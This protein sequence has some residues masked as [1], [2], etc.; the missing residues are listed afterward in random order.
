MKRLTALVPM[1]LTA[2]FSLPA[3]AS[4]EAPTAQLWQPVKEV[5]IQAD[6]P[7]LLGMPT[8]AELPVIDTLFNQGR[9]ETL[10][11]ASYWADLL[12][13]SFFG[14]IL[15]LG[16]FVVFNGKS[17]LANGFSGRKVARWSGMDVFIHWLGAISCL[18]LIIT[19]IVMAAGRFLLEP[20]M[21]TNSWMGV[22]NTSVGLH[23]MMA[24]PFLLGWAIMVVKWAAKQMPESCDIGW[25][26]VM[27]GYLNFGSFKNQH[28]D[29]GFANA[30]E[31]LW[32]WTF[33]LFGGVLVVSGLILMFPSLVATKDAAN[34]SLIL[35]LLSAAILGM[36][37]VVHIFMATVMSEGGMECMVSGYC[38]ENWAKQHHNLWFKELK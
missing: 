18:F 37:T 19:G 36:F 32:F 31:K 15:L 1:M 6:I 7:E 17:K 27:G 34:L 14:M 22:I 26:K 20:N 11:P 30:G 8:Q 16:I 29:A 9:I 10:A 3:I 5:A 38:D 28:P 21:A 13:Y 25:F 23:D 4:E 35:H 12:S 24:F 33:A 2:I